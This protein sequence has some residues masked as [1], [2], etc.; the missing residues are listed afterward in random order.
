MVTISSLV[1]LV[2]RRSIRKDL[3]SIRFVTEVRDDDPP[4]TFPFS[5]AFASVWRM[6]RVGRFRYRLNR[7]NRWHGC[8]SSIVGRQLRQYGGFGCI[9]SL[10]K[11]EEGLI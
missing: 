8:R 9:V 6:A 11:D 5:P 4:R 2:I 10:W 3:Q 1:L 7:L